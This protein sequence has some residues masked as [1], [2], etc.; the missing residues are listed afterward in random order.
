MQYKTES[1]FRNQLVNEM[2]LEGFE[3]QTIESGGT[4]RGIPDVYFAKLDGT[5]IGDPVFNGWIELKNITTELSDPVVI[6]FRAGQLEWLNRFAKAGVN[7]YLG[8][9]CGEGI[10]MFPRFE[11]QKTYLLKDFLSHKH[12]TKMKNIESLL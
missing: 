9:S 8:V 11:I 3:V 6:D 1:R 5:R 7:V 10:F 12:L 4:G 2:R